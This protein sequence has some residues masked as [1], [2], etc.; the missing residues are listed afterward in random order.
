MVENPMT[1]LAQ[2]RKLYEKMRSELEAEATG[3][4]IVIRN[5]EFI[6]K[7]DSF[8]AAAGEAVR[9]FGRG[10]YLI[11]EVGAPDVTLPA[12]VVYAVAHDA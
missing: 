12:S 1:I 3:K 9:R 11:R 10:P 6:G 4:W 8:E 2:E 7:Y 5:S